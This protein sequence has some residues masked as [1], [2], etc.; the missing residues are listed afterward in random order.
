MRIRILF[1]DIKAWV[2]GINN[3]SLNDC[4][5][6]TVSYPDETANHRGS[7]NNER[8]SNQNNVHDNGGKRRT[9]TLIRG[10]KGAERRLIID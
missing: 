2:V 5:G 9:L 8:E 6:S 4:Q 1:S 7:S 3:L 10:I